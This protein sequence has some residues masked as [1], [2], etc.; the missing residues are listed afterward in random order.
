[1]KHLALIAALTTTAIAGDINVVQ[2]GPPD[3]TRLE[4]ACG[5]A[6]QTVD[7]RYGGTTGRFALPE[8]EAQISLPNLEIP[9]LTVAASTAP[10][11]AVLSPAEKGY[12]WTL[13]PGKPTDE[14]W[15]MR[16]INLSLE[17][18][19]LTQA[20]DPLEIEPD[21]T[22]DLAVKGKG[23]MSISIEGGEKFS[24]DGSEPCAVLAI[25]YGKEGERKVLFVPD[26]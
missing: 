23:G 25:I 6:T 8:K 22:S 10:N 3:V 20:G 19:K 7:L 21:A 11:I 18:V 14:K 5:G 15:A 9:S 17:N 1:M 13:I 4:I 2:L 26:R 16:V 12:R 24:Y